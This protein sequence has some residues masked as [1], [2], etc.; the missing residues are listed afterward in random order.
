MVEERKIILQRPTRE[1]VVAGVSYDGQ[2]E[3][4]KVD[5]AQSNEESKLVYVSVDLSEEEDKE[6]IQLLKE[7]REVFA[8][9]YKD[10]KGV[11]L[12]VCQHTIPIRDNAK[13]CIQHPYSYNDTFSQKIDE[14]IDQIK[15]ARFIYEIEHKL[16]ISTLVVV[17][18]KNGK[19]R[20]VH[21]LKKSK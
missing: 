17:P 8:W 11:N 20:G 16:W 5:L 4:K 3:V 14:E 1:K 21:Q 2:E 13:P 6:L 10:L 7:F 18:K 15:E 9:S 12:D 19:L